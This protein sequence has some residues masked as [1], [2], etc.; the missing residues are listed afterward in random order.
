MTRND[1]EYFCYECWFYGLPLERI[2]LIEACVLWWKFWEA[3]NYYG[4]FERSLKRGCV[5]LPKF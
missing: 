2:V 1:I 3:S 4:P 5:N